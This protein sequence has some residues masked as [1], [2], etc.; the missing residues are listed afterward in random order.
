MRCGLR[1]DWTWKKL[2]LVRSGPMICA[3]EFSA[4]VMSLR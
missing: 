3:A 2:T 4:W 1:C